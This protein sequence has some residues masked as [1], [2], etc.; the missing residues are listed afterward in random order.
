MLVMI[1]FN[2]TELAQFSEIH[3]QFSN[4]LK[5]IGETLPRWIGIKLLKSSSELVSLESSHIPLVEGTES[6]CIMLV[7][8]EDGPRAYTRS[9][10]YVPHTRTCLQ[11][12]NSC[13]HTTTIAIMLTC[14][15]SPTLHTPSL[16][17][18]AGLLICT[19]ESGIDDS[20]GVIWRGQCGKLQY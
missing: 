6:S 10:K 8:I 12:V 11:Y 15:L 5:I 19:F 14:S 16:L 13:A 20:E 17:P 1:T 7:Y 9:S 3:S 2:V 4:Q 18:Q